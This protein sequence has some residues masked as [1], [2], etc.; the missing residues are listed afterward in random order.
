MIILKKVKSCEELAGVLE[1]YSQSVDGLVSKTLLDDL[2]KAAEQL[3]IAGNLKIADIGKQ[4]GNGA[5]SVGKSNGKKPS[6]RT[7]KAIDIDREKVT[8]FI[9]NRDRFVASAREIRV[10]FFKREPGALKEFLTLCDSWKP[11]PNA[12][13]EVK[14]AIEFA[15]FV[16]IAGYAFPERGQLWAAEGREKIDIESEARQLIES[17]KF[18]GRS[19][20]P[21]QNVLC[22]LDRESSTDK[23]I[24]EM[25]KALV[26]LCTTN[27]NLADHEAWGYR[28]SS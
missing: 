27:A 4:N 18:P 25:K 1:R 22:F 5:T 2:R 11:E 24:D 19:K 12:A 13:E 17:A 8:E 23:N 3:A 14:F 9:K 6:S 10:R 16:E 28:I 20:K 7:T 15:K 21:W 26:S